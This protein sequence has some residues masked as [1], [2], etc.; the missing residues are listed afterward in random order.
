MDKILQEQLMVL[1]LIEDFPHRVVEKVEGGDG[2]QQERFALFK[3][4]VNALLSIR[5]HSRSSINFGKRK[6]L[7]LS[8]AST[9]SKENEIDFGQDVG[10][11]PDFADALEA[12]R[13]AAAATKKTIFKKKRR[14]NI[15]EVGTRY[16]Q[17]FS[18]SHYGGS[19]LG[20]S[21]PHEARITSFGDHDLISPPQSTA[22]SNLHKLAAL[23][24]KAKK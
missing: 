16:Q 15:P 18:A 4:I 9:E 13:A 14:R 6:Q 2:E 10:K 3:Q 1:S 22:S 17:S 20:G 24:G 7:T 19:T 5:L 12:A 23:L 11:T 8:D 21:E